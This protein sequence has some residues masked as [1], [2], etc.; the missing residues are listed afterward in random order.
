MADLQTAQK[1]TYAVKVG[2]FAW[3]ML[4]CAAQSPVKLLCSDY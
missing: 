2:E 4:F 1:G 3:C